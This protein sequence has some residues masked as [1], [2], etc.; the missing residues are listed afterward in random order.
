VILLLHDSKTFGWPKDSEDIRF[1]NYM[2]IPDIFGSLPQEILEALVEVHFFV[3]FI[4]GY[5]LSFGI[6]N[7]AKQGSNS[8]RVAVVSDSENPAILGLKE[9]S[10]PSLHDIAFNTKSSPAPDRMI[11]RFV[12]SRSVD[13]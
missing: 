7:I 2:K 3:A 11:S 12:R 8:L 4:V 5:A 6:W 9:V 13:G 1:W 10:Y